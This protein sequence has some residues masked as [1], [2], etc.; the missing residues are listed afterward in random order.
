MPYTKH[1]APLAILFLAGCQP[2]VPDGFTREGWDRYQRTHPDGAQVVAWVHEDS[3]RQ[4]LMRRFVATYL[5]HGW[6]A[7]AARAI[8]YLGAEKAMLTGA[9]LRGF[10]VTLYQGQVQDDERARQSLSR[11][12]ISNKDQLKQ[13]DDT[14][15]IDRDALA[16]LSH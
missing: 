1:L 4:A 15:Q 3:S 8:F 10:M 2:S 13:A 11:L 16:A 5:R 6:D 9:D 7:E 14:L 12:G